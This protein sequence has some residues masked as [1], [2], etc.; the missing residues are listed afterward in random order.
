MLM[1]VALLGVMLP[2]TAHAFIAN[3]PKPQHQFAPSVASALD[4]RHQY[5]IAPSHVVV[6]N[7]RHFAARMADDETDNEEKPMIPGSSD[8]YAAAQLRELRLP[9]LV[10]GFILAALVR[11]L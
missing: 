3:A 7:R 4:P 9:L 2:P 1:R 6:S 10:I 5:Q 11:S 8:E